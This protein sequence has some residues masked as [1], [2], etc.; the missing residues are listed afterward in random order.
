MI[1]KRKH[2]TIINNSRNEMLQSKITSKLQQIRNNHIQ[3]VHRCVSSTIL[4]RINNFPGFPILPYITYIF[5]IFPH[6]PVFLIIQIG[7]I[8]SISP[9]FLITSSLCL[10]YLAIFLHFNFNSFSYLS[11]VCC[12]I[13]NRGIN[14]YLKALSI[15]ILF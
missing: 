15:N 9:V 13:V 10:P 12:E 4:K 6:F 11:R 1:E 8:F 5:H 3:I 2:K 7:L 14:Q